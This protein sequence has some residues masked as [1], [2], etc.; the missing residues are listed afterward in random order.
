LWEKRSSDSCN[1]GSWKE[2]AL[3]GLIDSSE[4]EMISIGGADQ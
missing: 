2:D 3:R 1:F 4:F